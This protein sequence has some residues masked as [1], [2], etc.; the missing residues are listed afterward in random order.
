MSD[1]EDAIDLY[2]PNDFI[3]LAMG[4]LAAERIGAERLHEFRKSIAGTRERSGDSLYL[5]MWEEILDK[6]EDAVAEA[7]TETSQRGQ[8]LRSVISFRAFVTKAERDDIVRTHTRN[9]F[10]R[11]S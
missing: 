2:L 10:S 4:R 8:I 5:R 11:V 3:A 1:H 6:G 7:L 9:G